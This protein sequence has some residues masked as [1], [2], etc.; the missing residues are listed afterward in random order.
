MTVLKLDLKSA[1]H[2]LFETATL[3][4][5]DAICDLTHQSV[6]RLC[7]EDHQNDPKVMDIWLQRI[8]SER[9]EAWINDPHLTVLL[10]WYA[11]QLSIV[12]AVRPRPSIQ[13]TNK[14]K[15]KLRRTTE[16]QCRPELRSPRRP[17]P[18]YR[19]GSNGRA[20][21][22][23]A[24]PRRSVRRSAELENRATLLSFHWL[25]RYRV[26]STLDT[27]RGLHR[28]LDLPAHAKKIGKR[29]MTS[30]MIWSNFVKCA[31]CVLFSST[32]ILTSRQARAHEKHQEQEEP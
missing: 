27:P 30:L 19:Q 12:G 11:E 29:P 23:H 5:R 14:K 17:L 6:Q 9:V 8:S 1:R 4:H 24:F 7:A 25:R 2:P 13:A 16:R 20:G 22:Y 32:H 18:R 3:A 31:T 21:T 15:I 10:A 26:T 28:P